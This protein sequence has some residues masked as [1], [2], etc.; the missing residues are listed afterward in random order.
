MTRLA[1][2]SWSSGKDCTLALHRARQEG[3]LEVVA[4]LSTFNETASRV[5]IHGTRR[6]VAR[7]QARALGLPLIEVDL[8]AP[9]SNADY[10]ARIGAASLRLKEQ[11]IRDWIFGD[12]FLEDIR[13]YR[14]ANLAAQGLSGH[15]PLWGADT[16]LLAQEMLDLGLDARIATL[17]PRLVPRE[18][19]GS[20]YDRAFLDQLPPEVDPCGERGEFHTVVAN[21]PGFAAP[22][23][24][25]Q[26]E[27][28]ERSGFVYTDFDMPPSEQ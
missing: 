5:A 11:G 9:C 3:E 23:D 25:R 8:P 26:G 24:L 21:G 14:E 20:R 6:A 22:L 13:R 15:F 12:L 7:A 1:V 18:L 4:L 19:C 16:R 28:V 27:T 10:E 2:M 17:D